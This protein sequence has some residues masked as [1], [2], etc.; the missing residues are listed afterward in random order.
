ML[1]AAAVG[2]PFELYS[3]LEGSVSVSLSQE[4]LLTRK[5]PKPECVI[6]PGRS[7]SFRC[8]FPQQKLSAAHARVAEARRA[9]TGRR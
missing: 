4:T 2:T 5:V 9:V 8:D 1:V 7:T 3:F 6:Y